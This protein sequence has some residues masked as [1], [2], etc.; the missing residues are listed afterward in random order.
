MAETTRDEL[1]G[2][3]VLYT[4]ACLH[5]CKG[6]TEEELEC[7]QK[8]YEVAAT[9]ND[10]S[11]ETNALA[12]LTNLT[13]RE[14]LE[15]GFYAKFVE[16]Q[17]VANPNSLPDPL[18]VETVDSRVYVMPCCRKCLPAEACSVVRETGI[19][20]ECARHV[21]G[22]RYPGLPTCMACKQ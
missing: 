3:Q 4:A 21:C 5:G 12:A 9:Q 2:A 17:R 6:E 8:A 19:C 13:A 11:L 18:E 14:S 10:I 20:P 16:R 22:R 1:L 7:L 15:T